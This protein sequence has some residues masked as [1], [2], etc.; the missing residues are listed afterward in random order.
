[1][2]G[3]A[4]QAVSH[5]VCVCTCMNVITGLEVSHIKSSTH[6]EYVQQLG[7]CEYISEAKAH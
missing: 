2:A 4:C 7:E 6:V 3:A 1:M 5:R